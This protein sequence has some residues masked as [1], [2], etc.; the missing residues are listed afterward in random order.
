MAHMTYEEQIAEAR[1]KGRTF[2]AIYYAGITRN[3]E[4]LCDRLKWLVQN[5]PRPWDD[6][7]LF[8]SLVNDAKAIRKFRFA[9]VDAEFAEVEANEGKNTKCLNP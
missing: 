9:I 8:D 1:A 3:V 5:T 4:H 7:D 6:S 2:E